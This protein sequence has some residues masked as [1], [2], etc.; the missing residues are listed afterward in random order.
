MFTALAAASL[1]AFGPVDRDGFLARASAVKVGMSPKEVRRIL[2]AAPVVWNLKDPAPFGDDVNTERWVWGTQS[3][4]SFPTWGTIRF[5]DGGVDSI[6]IP[7]ASLGLWKTG[8]AEVALRAIERDLRPGGWFTGNVPGI[9]ERIRVIN[10]LV[11]LGEAKAASALYQYACIR[12][13]T[14]EDHGFLSTVIRSL[15]I[16]RPSKSESTTK[17]SELA[18]AFEDIPFDLNPNWAFPHPDQIERELRDARKGGDFRTAPLR[19][20]DDPYGAKTRILASPEWQKVER[21]RP[22]HNVR[23]MRSQLVSELYSLLRTVRPPEDRARHIGVDR[24][25]V[26]WD[27]VR[28]VS[29]PITYPEMRWDPKRQ[30]YVRKDGFFQNDFVAAIP[31][32]IVKAT[33]DPKV[34]QV[35]IDRRARNR[36]DITFYYDEKRLPRPF[37]VLL[38]TPAQRHRVVINPAS[39]DLDFAEGRPYTLSHSQSNDRSQR[40]IQLSRSD[41][42]EIVVRRSGAVLG[43]IQVPKAPASMTD[44]P[45][46]DYPPQD[47]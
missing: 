28:K 37:E 32:R 17:G 16:P 44:A 25:P 45:E 21:G 5:R 1:V 24:R 42:T 7:P 4:Y 41:A 23:A 22:A 20:T 40:G 46:Y 35:T 18:F 36:I 34:E 19:P 8:E 10:T 29:F 33:A 2:G 13:D 38:V 11:G 31:L 26:R 27:E 15:Y 6:D 30:A 14:N 3:R 47:F 9:L 12:D 39:R 43:R